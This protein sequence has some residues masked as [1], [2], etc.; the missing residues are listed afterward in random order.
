[1]R[2]IQIIAFISCLLFYID[3]D[4]QKVAPAMTKSEVY[5]IGT[6]QYPS[7]L[8]NR[9]DIPFK[10]LID[11]EFIKV[12]SD[13]IDFEKIRPNLVLL[14]KGFV[15]PPSDV[16]KKKAYGSISVV[17]LS[18]RY[19]FPKTMSANQLQTMEQSMKKN[20]ENNMA[21]TQY[22]LKK[23]YPF[24]FSRINGIPSAEYSY[25]LA[26]KGRDEMSN[27][28]TCLYDSDIQVQIILSA[29]K[30]EFKKWKAYHD[31]IVGTFN[32]KMNVAD[33]FTF[34][35]KTQLQDRND[36]PFKCMV[37]KEFKE[38]LG[39]SADYEQ[40]RPALLLLEND[41]TIADS[42]NIPPFGN[43][44]LNMIPE[45]SENIITK[46]SIKID[47]FEAN[48]KQ[49]IQ[50]NL[51]P[52]DYKITKW[53]PFTVTEVAGYPAIEYSYEQQ[54]GDMASF[55]NRA[56]YIFTPSTQLH[57]NMSSPQNDIPFWNE[58]YRFIL[59]SF[60]RLYSIPGMG[61]VLAP[62]DFVEER[63]NIPFVLLVDEESKK[64]LGDS[65]DY[66][67]FR[68][69][70]LF[71]QKGF[72]EKDPMQLKSF[73]SITIDGKEGNFTRLSNPDSLSVDLVRAEFEASTKRNLARTGYKLLNWGENF[74]C[75]APASHREICYSYTQ[76]K[77]GEEPKVI[78]IT[79]FV[80]KAKQ[81][82]F[83][84]TCKQSDYNKW[85]P[86]YDRLV[87]S[88]RFSGWR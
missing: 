54:L 55:E 61:T 1:M 5:N 53:N 16:K 62:S 28:T 29:P 49:S 10:S 41:F 43:I 12:L 31:R 36:M 50:D 52:T 73:N 66:E 51:E 21:G 70:L 76:Q 56:T 34:E 9:S 11:E 40:F 2:A 35:Y 23:W 64:V 67:Q 32:R 88:F 82:G 17:F 86:E 45:Y 26:I 24:N 78:S 42:T 48:I 20:T 18:G 57:L 58:N 59:S 6:I 13:T 15:L 77:E 44:T 83:I 80:T 27:V 46:D 81:I 79:Y 8:E 75:S 22:I 19:K 14:E 72:N 60:Q 63:S 69:D 25:D 33:M 71:L 4:A 30:K 85:C 39:D 37:D 87:T 68:P 3:A 65:I 7:E 74:K 84:M 38:I 47:V